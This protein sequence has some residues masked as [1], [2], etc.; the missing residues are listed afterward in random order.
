MGSDSLHALRRLRAHSHS[1]SLQNYRIRLWR[2]WLSYD[3][4]MDI[5]CLRWRSDDLGYHN[6]LLPLS[7]YFDIEVG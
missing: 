2:R 6:L 3:P 1:I 4:R 5:V 7:K